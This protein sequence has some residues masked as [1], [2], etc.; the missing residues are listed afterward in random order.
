M[1]HI[2][3]FI[4]REGIHF[5]LPRQ[6]NGLLHYPCEFTLADGAGIL[7]PHPEVF[8]ETDNPDAARLFLFPLDIGPFVDFQE[9]ESISGVISALPHFAGR[10]RR[11][12]VCDSGDNVAS[13]GPLVCLFKRSVIAETSARAVVSWYDV[14]AHVLAERPEFELARVRYDVSFV[15]VYS[16]IARKAAV[17]SIQVEAPEL[18]FFV[19]EWNSMRVDKSAFVVDKPSGE[20]LRR[21]Q[22]LF[23]Q[24]IKDSVAVLCPP[25][26]GPQSLR[27]YEVMYLGRIQVFF[28]R[29]T[30]YPLEDKI[31]YDSFGLFIE[32]EHIMHTGNIL[33][34]WFARQTS[35]S[36]LRRWVT[37]CKV[38]NEF[39]APGRK[40]KSLLAEAKA[41]FDL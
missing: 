25:G 30:V 11:H 15:G 3:C 16:N 24:S 21:R 32:P 1:E 37:A 27:A 35:G 4:Y 33:R 20:I 41:K 34:E 17:R 8:T 23:V 38:W 31:D 6:L 26:V 18:R 10:E 5:K 13:I 28:G 2:P 40:L 9:H 29:N 7:H 19:N 22:E 14:P 12:V 39:F 36:L